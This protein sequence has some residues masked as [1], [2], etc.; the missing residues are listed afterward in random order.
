M[1]YDC[2]ERLCNP[3]GYFEI[4]WMIGEGFRCAKE[5]RNLRVEAP[6]EMEMDSFENKWNRWFKFKCRYNVSLYWRK[7]E[8]K[9]KIRK[10]TAKRTSK[11]NTFIIAS[12]KIHVD[13]SIT[14]ICIFISNRLMLFWLL[15]DEWYYALI[16]KR[17]G[18][19]LS[20]AYQRCSFVFCWDLTNE[21]ETHFVRIDVSLF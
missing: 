18:C 13:V 17:Y 7:K 20:P 8:W 10:K 21:T 19:L 5:S 15:H 4:G 1:L 9:R 6:F 11:K 14:F 3:Y 16:C 12:A 2:R